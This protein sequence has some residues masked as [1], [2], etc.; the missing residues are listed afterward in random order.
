M[1]LELSPPFPN[2]LPHLVLQCKVI[3]GNIGPRRQIHMVVANSVLVHS[4]QQY[5]IAAQTK[6]HTV[7]IP[8]TK[9]PELYPPFH[10]V[11]TRTHQGAVTE[12]AICLSNLHLD[13]MM[14]TVALK[15]AEVVVGLAQLEIQDP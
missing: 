5:R 3:P 4:L 6:P 13:P 2:D 14:A 15:E 11:T 8:T 12:I 1:F 9:S 7:K 10:T